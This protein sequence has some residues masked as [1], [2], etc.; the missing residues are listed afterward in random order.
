MTTYPD[1]L[2]RAATLLEASP[3]AWAKGSFAC[4]LA[5]NPVSA[6]APIAC[7]WCAL[8][9][10]RRVA[11]NESEANMASW[12]VHK[13]LRN[14]NYNNIPAWNDDPHRNRGDVISMFRKL[15]EL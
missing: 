14:L 9:A 1:T 10:I 3:T 12:I 8:G 6:K 4:D 15:A 13:E 5:G 11:F 7:S 2:N